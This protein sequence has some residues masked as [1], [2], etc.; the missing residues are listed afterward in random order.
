MR[1]KTDP[2][3]AVEPKCSS[4]DHSLVSGCELVD[5][6][7]DDKK[8]YEIEVLQRRIKILVTPSQDMFPKFTKGD[9][10]FTV[11][12]S[13]SMPIGVL[14]HKILLALINQSG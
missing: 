14:Q 8:S 4:T 2:A 1:I 3:L 9:N 12:V 7:R 13:R 5:S 11:F 10:P 6:R